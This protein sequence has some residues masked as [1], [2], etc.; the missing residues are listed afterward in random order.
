LLAEG[1]SPNRYKIGKQADVLMLFYLFSTEALTDIFNRLGYRF[2]PDMIPAN[3][4]YYAQRVTHGST[5]SRIVHSWVLARLDRR[6][7]WGFFCEGLRSD[8][9][10]VQKGTTAEGIHLGAMSGAVDIIQRCFTGIEMRDDILW[11]NP[12]LPDEL[13]ALDFRIRYA[14]H[15]L[16]CSI[17][18][19]RLKIRFERSWVGPVRVGYR[20]RVVTMRQGDVVE[21][22]LRQLTG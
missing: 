22:E 1:D 7:A 9:G 18:H 15:W 20:E 2:T 8:L 6:S 3:I 4:N 14:G 12:I 5:L 10:D 11:F 16:L 13:M 19:A 17:N 21:F